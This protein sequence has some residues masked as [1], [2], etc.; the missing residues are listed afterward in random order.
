VENSHSWSACPDLKRASHLSPT[1]ATRASA[2]AVAACCL[3]IYAPGCFQP[4]LKVSMLGDFHITVPSLKESILHDL[5]PVD[6]RES[7]SGHITNSS[8]NS[9]MEGRQGGREGERNE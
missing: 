7:P 6:I 3:P 8:L 5:S 9:T 4:V 1:S 2:E